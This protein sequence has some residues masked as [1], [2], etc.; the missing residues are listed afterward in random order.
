MESPSRRKRSPLGQEH[1]VLR[2]HQVAVE[3][4]VRRRLVHA[5]VGVHVARQRTARLLTHQLPPVLGLGHEVR[6]SRRVQKHRGP[7]HGVEAAG[8]NR[9]P[10]VLADLNGQGHAGLVRDLEEKVDPEGAGLATESDLALPRLSRRGEPALLVVLLVSG[11]V[12][13][14]HHAEDLAVLDDGCRIVEPSLL[15]DR[16]TDHHHRRHALGLAAE[17]PEGP[18]GPCDEG[19]EAEEEV[20]AGVAGEAQLGQDQDLHPVLVGSEHALHGRVGVALGVGHADRR[21]GR[22]HAQEA[23]GCRAHDS[24]GGTMV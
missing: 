20:G 18:L 2:H 14:G 4:E 1:P 7:G 21:A 16:Q 23:M 13:L 9:R 3:D 19:G 15:L 17:T 10:E 8:W 24:L 12:G 22:R 5:G 11:Q 6:R